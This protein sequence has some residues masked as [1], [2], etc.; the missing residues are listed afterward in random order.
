[1]KALLALAMLT[2]SALAANTDTRVFE[3]RTYYAAPGKLDALHA[4]FRDHTTKLFEK[5]GITNIGYWTPIENPESK[6]VYVLAYPTREARDV[7]WKEFAADPE[8]K[9][10]QAESEKDG[11]LVAK[12]EQLFFTATDFSPEIKPS[13]S[14][15]GRI[16]ELRTYTTPPGRLEN[17]HARFRDHTIALFKKHGMTNLFYWKLLPEQPKNANLLGTPDTT[18]IY[19]LAHASPEGAKASFDAFRADPEWVAVRKASE[20]KAGGSLTVEKDGVKSVFL[21]ATDY[22]PTK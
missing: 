16:F 18:L 15:D 9:A 2:A 4:R 3:M 20:E 17:L 7:S 11:K 1:M 10:A 6:L 8:W 21:K 14:T 19:L 22:S 13:I 5:H 12:V